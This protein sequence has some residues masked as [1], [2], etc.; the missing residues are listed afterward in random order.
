MQKKFVIVTPS[1]GSNNGSFDVVCAENRDT[2]RSTTIIVDGRDIVKTVN[3]NQNMND[4]VYPLVYY[5]F[6]FTSIETYEVQQE[7]SF[8][9]I[10]AYIHIT[11]DVE[12]VDTQ[13]G[14]YNLKALKPDIDLAN[15]CTLQQILID[16]GGVN[17]VTF[18]FSAVGNSLSNKF[19][20]MGVVTIPTEY[21]DNFRQAIQRVIDIKSNYIMFYMMFNDTSIVYRINVLPA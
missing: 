13:V 16:Y 5:M 4:K 9:T 2:A 18:S 8:Y 10:D 1:S 19:N 11:D 17:P 6:P 20:G 15:G 14:L 12:I 7:G 3:V 21:K